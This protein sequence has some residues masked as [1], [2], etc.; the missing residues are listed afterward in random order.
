MKQPD[1]R[2]ELKY[3]CS[4]AELAMLDIRLRTLMQPDPHVG[5]NGRYQIRSIYFDDPAGRCLQENEDGTS[6]REKWRIRIYDRSDERIALECKRRESGMIRKQSCLLTRSQYEELM[7]KEH[8]PLPSDQYPPLLNRLLL[9]KRTAGYAPRVIVQYERT[10]WIYAPGNVRVTF[11]RN[12]GSSDAIGCF[13]EGQLPSR[14]ILP[15]GVQLLE[16]KYDAFLPDL[17]YRAVQ[18]QNMQQLS[19]SK[20]CLCRRYARS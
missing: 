8:V 18:M 16:V 19:F 6:P 3:L 13:F 2:H 9:L 11:D 7:N 5:A 1:F 4:D 12:I 20:Y 14:P 10:P 15:T 17:V